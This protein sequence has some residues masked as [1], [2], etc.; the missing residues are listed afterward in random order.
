MGILVALPIAAAI[1]ILEK[2]KIEEF[3]FLAIGIIVTLIIGSGFYGNTMYGVMGAVG[4]GALALLYCICMVCINRER[5]AKSVLTPGLLGGMFCVGI[6]AFLYIGKADLGNENDTFWAHIPQVINMYRYSDMGNSGTR[7]ETFSLLYTAPVY[8]SWCYF[9]NRLWYCY[10]DGINLWAR[11]IFIIAGFMPLFARLKKTE[12]KKILCI[13][14]LIFLLPLMVEAKYDFM[15]DICI[16]AA[17]VYG[18]I[19]TLKLY[20]DR[21]R[22]NDPGYLFG[23]CI[24]LMLISVMKRAGGIYTY[25]IVTVATVYTIDRFADRERKAGWLRKI[26]P[27]VLM[28]LSVA[29]TKCFSDYRAAYYLED[30]LFTYAP[31]VSFV[32]FLLLGIFCGILRTVFEKRKY[33]LGSILSAAFLL[34]GVRILPVVAGML[35][36]KIYV[37]AGGDMG[38]NF[39]HFFAMW[40]ERQYFEGERFG[41]GWVLPDVVFILLMVG[42]LLLLRHLAEQQRIRVAVTAED[43]DNVILPLIFGYV[44]FMFFYCFICM[45]IGTGYVLDGNIRYADRYFGPAILLM[46]AVVIYELLGIRDVDHSR[47]LLGIGAVL[48]L[49]LPNNPFRVV[50]LESDAGWDKHNELYEKAGITFSD[51]D[52]LLCIGPDHCQ[53]YVFPARSDL[54]YEVKWAQRDA[55]EWAQ[56]IMARGYRYLLLEDYNWDF[57]DKYFTMFAGGKNSIQKWAIYDIVVEGDKVSFVKRAGL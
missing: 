33:I 13:S 51:D 25:G 35:R 56:E 46:T 14:G 32:L 53:Y 4:V 34:G 6:A 22:Y 28:A 15:P 57:P 5:V 39:F 54:D 17:I 29:V 48:L 44:I 41:N 8:T 42:V 37:E 24:W 43:L 38:E 18:T 27:L 55:Q 9:C 23:I 21:R 47:L 2:R 11:Q 49:L 36:G 1:A 52:Y 31:F 26:L 50:S 10:S 30:K 20:R 16:G 3:L 12:W 40:F 19:T 45:A 7:A